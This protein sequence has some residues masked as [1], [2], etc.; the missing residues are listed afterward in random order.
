M[1]SEDLYKQVSVFKFRTPV[2][3]T[4]NNDQEFLIVDVVITFCWYHALVV[5]CHQ[6]KNSFVVILKEDSTYHKVRGVC[7]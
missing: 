6:V 1:V 2:F 4:V 3:K 5:E 7:L